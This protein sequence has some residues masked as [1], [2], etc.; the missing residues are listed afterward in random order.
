MSML[1]LLLV[2][3]LVFGSSAEE[4]DYRG[5]SQGDLGYAEQ[6]RATNVWKAQLGYVNVFAFLD[7]SWNYSYRQAVMLELLKK[8]LERSGFLDILFFV[9]APSSNLPENSVENNI[10][11]RTWKEISKNMVGQEYIWGVEETQPND[12]EKNKGK[13][14]V[15]LRDTPELG[16]W[17]HFRASR[18][19]VVVLDRC[20]KLTYQVIIPWSILYFP[21]V[22]AA[23][24]STYKEY[25]CGPCNEQPSPVYNT[26]EYEKYLF[27][28][29]EAAEKSPD[30]YIEQT[31][32]NLKLNFPELFPE[33][34]TLL[35]KEANA[36]EKHENTSILYSTNTNLDIK[37]TAASLVTI[38]DTPPSKIDQTEPTT[39]VSSGQGQTEI[40]PTVSDF[41]TTEDY[42]ETQ[43][44]LENIKDRAGVKSAK[45]QIKDNQDLP[46][47]IIL[48]APHV[49]QEN[50]TS[51]E[52]THLILKSGSPDYHDHFHSM[53]G[54][55]EQEPKVNTNS[56]SKLANSPNESPGVYGE[57]AYYW[58]TTE[59]DEFNNQDENTELLELD[60]DTM[61]GAETK[62]DDTIDS[63]D[64][65]L[66][67]SS[68]DDATD[69]SMKM[70]VDEDS[71]EFVQRR[72]IEH[73]NKL[74]PW[75]RYIL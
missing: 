53:S 33:N 68:D 74:V 54:I 43:E 47:R 63:D 15:F 73:Y 30:P 5:G 55:Y 39:E 46:L 59:D 1:T 27:E 22:K 21:Y 61:E 13:G 2:V 9:V 12:Q 75:I 8:R 69:A 64:G 50:Q 67:Q 52:Y 45:S 66:V 72:L 16:I 31:P 26:V 10:E 28:N 37:E 51:K 38:T 70:K 42:R 44:E 57:I 35:S 25:P 3:A 49:H 19:E 34:L 11:I 23:I 6:C 62:I 17:H 58:R 36:E 7:P 65:T 56:R 20:G 18:D 14:I 40:L 24:L 71:E 4:E 32:H 60:D 48:Y 29:A 41:K